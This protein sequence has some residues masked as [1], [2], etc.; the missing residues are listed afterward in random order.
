V[1]VKRVSQSASGKTILP[2]EQTGGGHG[3]L[4]AKYSHSN[5]I[6]PDMVATR[7]ISSH[8]NRADFKF[9]SSIPLTSVEISVPKRNT[10][11]SSYKKSIFYRKTKKRLLM[12]N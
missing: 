5:T 9:K 3:D 1:V 4:S 6:L 7:N 12:P 2:S 10:S 8:G 11:M